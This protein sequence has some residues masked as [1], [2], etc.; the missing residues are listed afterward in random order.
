M[1]VVPGELDTSLLTKNTTKD[2]TFRAFYSDLYDTN[3]GIFKRINSLIMNQ[4][5]DSA[6]SLNSTIID[7]NQ[8]E[9]NL[10]EVY[11]VY[12][13]KVINDSTLSATDS[14]TL[15]AIAVQDPI[16]GGSAVFIARSILFKE[17]HAE[18]AS[19]RLIVVGNQ[20]CT[21]NGK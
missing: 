1:V 18:S 14:S 19:L 12:I 20:Q 8:I 17:M 10:K 16:N 13:Q 11:S 7:T 21:E 4:Y 5:L 6:L 15:E 2:I 3:I 9:T